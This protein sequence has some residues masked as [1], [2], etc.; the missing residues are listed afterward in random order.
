MQSSTR[1]FTLMD[2]QSKRFWSITQNLNQLIISQGLS[3]STQ[4]EIAQ[5]FE[6]Q[7]SAR[8]AMLELISEKIKAG[9][10]EDKVLLAPSSSHNSRRLPV[11]ERT[12][13]QPTHL[14]RARTFKVVEKYGGTSKYPW[15]RTWKITVVW[16]ENSFKGNHQIVVKLFD[17][18][19]G[20][21]SSP[22][23]KLKFVSDYS[24]SVE[25]EKAFIEIKDLDDLKQHVTTSNAVLLDKESTRVPT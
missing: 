23:F 9:Y 11:P 10:V 14:I 2:G 15:L 4:S 20:V 8:L 24:S 25:A 5:D 18:P 1:S 7:D 13:A 12:T 17:R 19:Y 16:I 22:L 21:D 6:S 3:E